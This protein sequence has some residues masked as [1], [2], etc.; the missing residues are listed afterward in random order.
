MSTDC[1]IHFV[2]NPAK[3]FYAGQLLSGRVELTFTDSK[4]VRGKHNY[5][6]SMGQL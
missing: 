4:T 1:S 5:F 6:L 2:D 3:V